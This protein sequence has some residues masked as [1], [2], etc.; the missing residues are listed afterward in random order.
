MFSGLQHMNFRGSFRCGRPH[1]QAQ[2]TEAVV[3]IATDSPTTTAERNFQF[4]TKS[5]N[6]CLRAINAIR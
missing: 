1:A 3:S 4:D 5:T 2:V 6:M